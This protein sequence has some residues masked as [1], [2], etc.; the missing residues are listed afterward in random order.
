MDNIFLYN[1]STSM[2]YFYKSIQQS[3]SIFTKESVVVL[4]ETDVDLV[5]F[6]NPED[7]TSNGKL[8]ILPG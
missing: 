4:N 2:K 1:Q 5:D 6:E 3:L 7:F 8:H